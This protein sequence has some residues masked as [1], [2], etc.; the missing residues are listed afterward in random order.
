MKTIEI[1]PTK[2]S[3]TVTVPPSKS[4]CHRAVLAAALAKGT[5]MIH[6]VVL[7]ED[8]AA[9]VAAVQALGADVAFDGN[10]CQ[11]KGGS[12]K[13]NGSL[14]LDCKE[15]GSTLRF[16]IPL[17]LA[18]NNTA[19][20]IGSGNLYKR[21]LDPYLEIFQQQNISYSSKQLPMEIK[22]CLK[23]GRFELQG[24]ISSQFVTGLMLAL[25]LL[26]QPS[27]IAI[28]GAL[29]SSSYVDLTIDTLKSF[30]IEVNNDH[31]RTFEIKGNQM[32]I[33]TEYVVEGDFSQAAF[34]IAAGLLGERVQCKNLNLSS[35]Q[36]DKVFIDI[37]KSA[38]AELKYG[39]NCI[40]AQPSR[41]TAFEA[42]VSQCPDLAPI[43]AVVAACCEGV[44][45]ITGA[46]RLRMK[47]CDR[48]H[49]ITQELNKLGAEVIEMSDHMVIKGKQNLT[50]GIVDSWGDHRI[51][52]AL[53]IAS[54]KCKD[55]VVI[56][57]SSAITK[58]Y[59]S[60]FDDFESLGGVLYEL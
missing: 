11:I 27:I 4:L 33:P 5:S 57:N 60:F 36:G 28:R 25:P 21:P 8:I 38:G 16:L 35:S 29:E 50:G 37:L 49:A 48:L 19:A 42:N 40:E 55:K 47:E 31:Y 22:G 30:G 24:N 10:H 7:S 26:D 43:L 45:R 15:S 17:L 3:G 6:N 56:R 18:L 14:L 2:L 54:I 44:S 46:A 9:T 52:M 32:Y 1:I 12:L 51:A 53:A 13:R 41:L 23:P 20:Y 58:S 59:S 39:E 34:W